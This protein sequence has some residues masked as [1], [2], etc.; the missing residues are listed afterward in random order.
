MSEYAPVI[1]TVAGNMLITEAIQKKKPLV[2][3]KIGIGDGLID[4]ES[5]ELLTGLKHQ[6]LESPVTDKKIHKNGN[7]DIITT[8]DNT[9]VSTGF[10]AR[11]LGVFAKVGDDGEEKLFGY[12]NAGS[13]ASYTPVD[14]SLDEKI[15]TITFGIGSSVNVQI[16]LNSQMYVTRDMLTNELSKIITGNANDPNQ[17]LGTSVKLVKGLLST[18]KIKDGKDVV[19]ALGEET[20]SSLGVRYS[21]SN[22]NGWYICFGQLF[23]NVVIQGNQKYY[24]SDGWVLPVAVS[25]ILTMQATDT[26]VG[27][28]S[29][30]TE[31]V[32]GTRVKVHGTNAN[33][34][35]QLLVVGIV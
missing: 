17:D 25:Q 10:F 24:G 6:I 27:S 31:A 13:H 32:S 22:Q 14:K 8:I 11:E 28:Y 19:K 20:L 9:R 2:F 23:G 1:T 12:T 35:A 21:F 33:R 30:G 34:Q 26:G 16:E 4:S 18:L 5:I 29:Y 15:I 3:T 7:V